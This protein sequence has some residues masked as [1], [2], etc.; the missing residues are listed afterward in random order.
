MFASSVLM[1]APPSVATPLLHLYSDA[2]LEGA[3]VPGLGG[4]MHG[5]HWEL[6]LHGDELLLPIS[7]LELI[8]IGINLVVFAPLAQGARVLLCSDSLN[9]VQVLTNLRAKSPLMAR[10]HLKIL[11]LPQA[12]VLGDT[13]AALHCYGS[14]N[15]LADAVS[16]GNKDYFNALCAQL[17]VAPV[18]LPVLP[19]ARE[20]LDDAVSYAR[21]HGSLK[22]PTPRKPARSAAQ[23]AMEHGF[24]NEFSSD[25]TGDGPSSSVNIS[26][27]PQLHFAAVPAPQWSI[28]QTLHCRTPVRSGTIALMPLPA[29][30]PRV[31]IPARAQVRERPEVVL[32]GAGA[33]TLLHRNL[34]T[35]APAVVRR[36][37]AQADGGASRCA[38]VSPDALTCR[39]DIAPAPSPLTASKH[40]VMPLLRPVSKTYRP[41]DVLVQTMPR[42]PT[43]TTLRRR[44]LRLDA[45]HCQST[46]MV[47]LLESDQSHLALRPKDPQAL[48]HLCFATLAAAESTPAS[49][50]SK[51]DD[52]A[53]ERWCWYCETMST[54]PLRDNASLHP[55]SS[56]TVTMRETALLC[57]FLLY[58]ADSMPG[59]GG[60]ASAKPQSN[61]QMVLAV[62]RVHERMGAHM[63]ILHGVRKV[64]DSLIKNFVAAHGPE[65][66]VPARKEPLDGPRLNRL[67]N[68]PN[69]TAL[70]SKT[71]DWANAYWIAW[72]A[73]LSC[74]FAAAFR[75]AEL[76]PSLH[77]AVG[78]CDLTRASITWIVGGVAI[79]NPLTEQLA[80]LTTGDYCVVKPPTSKADPFGLHFTT[81][82]IYLPFQDTLGNAAK[83]VAILVTTVPV[84]IDQQ[85]SVPLFSFNAEGATMTHAEA[86][87]VLQHALK[88]AFPL[89]DSSRWSM[90]SLRIGAATA[91]M[92]AGASMELIQALCR[93][94]S[95]KSVNIYA[96]LGAQDYGTWLVRAQ[97]E[98]AD[99]STTRN[100]PR[101][102]YDGIV[103]ALSGSIDAWDGDGC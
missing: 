17:G 20:L 94:R 7:V 22:T 2:A 10:V 69:G 14:A 4:Y 8:A 46:N 67:F 78:P 74:G 19:S 45:L 6:A 38:A 96:R 79:A 42:T 87:R 77:T 24:G 71:I 27:L 81:K 102:D 80:G 30:R 57:G 52:L 84:S 25:V 95:P 66:L 32:N 86:S 5:F 98:H 59:R 62:R 93:W 53:W 58:L 21:S 40:R 13:A 48:H 31:P 23:L 15:P 50:T 37:S 76:L 43:K 33:S 65:M 9:C 12:A 100:L 39:M 91:L 99:S 41:Q 72:R 60:N 83:N 90:H 89:A 75:K 28:S 18:K 101:F 92:K 26:N 54:P 29:P 61:F 3:A 82:P 68:L 64:Y 55:A 16:R 56:A 97:A 36:L 1:P 49:S 85:P 34:K 51:A 11:E 47:R 88:A 70:G 63:E 35:Y 103:E 44:T 73:M